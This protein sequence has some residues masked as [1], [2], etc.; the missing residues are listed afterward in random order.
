MAVCVIDLVGKKPFHDV[1]GDLMSVAGK[2]NF[3]QE[4]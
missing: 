3:G 2:A 1:Q 4:H